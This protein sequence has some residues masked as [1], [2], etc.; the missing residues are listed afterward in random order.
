MCVNPYIRKNKMLGSG[1]NQFTQKIPCGKCPQCAKRKISDWMFRFEQ[2]SKV[3]RNARFVTLTYSNEYLPKT[4]EGKPTLRKKDFQDFIKRLRYYENKDGNKKR[5]V[6]Y[7]V[8][9]YGSKRGRP[10]YH[11]I[12]YN[13]GNTDNISNAWKF[14]RLEYPEAG[15][16]SVGYTLKYISKPKSAKTQ[17]R[18]G[19]F[20]LCSAGIGKNYISNRTIE[21]HNSDVRNSYVRTE[22]GAKLAIPKYYKEKIYTEENR[23][24]LTKHLETRAR[25]MH[26]KKVA[27]N[28]KR[29]SVKNSETNLEIRKL[30][31]RFEK[32]NESL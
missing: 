21:W 20:S 13:C 22:I 17:D 5:I 28:A 16:G 29:K 30:N 32:R 31:S 4:Q 12:V 18:E 1:E 7:G 6:Y 26:E 15:N 19:E 10:H 23:K 14:G 9:E 8:G 25:V 27:K 11:A 2:E 24:K 3:S